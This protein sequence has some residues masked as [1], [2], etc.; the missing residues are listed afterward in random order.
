M[1]DLLL[2]NSMKAG[3]RSSLEKIYREHFNYLYNY[4]RKMVKDDELIADC[5]QDL[6]VDIWNKRSKL[7]ETDSIRKYLTVV[8]RRKIVRMIKSNRIIQASDDLEQMTFDIELSIENKIVQSE[9][10][11]ILFKKLSDCVDQLSARQKEII[12]LKYYS[13]LNNQEIADVLGINNQSVRNL[14]SRTLKILSKTIK[15]LLF[16]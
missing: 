12:Y 14:I 13:G 11:S 16:I 9:E 3:N 2:W 4:C 5:I 8:V 10:K 7:S 15:F 1:S 6:F